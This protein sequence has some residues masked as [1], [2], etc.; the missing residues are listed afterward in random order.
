MNGRTP[1]RS[2][3]ASHSSV[4]ANA[5]ASRLGALVGLTIE[6]GAFSSGAD[7]PD[8][9]AHLREQFAAL[10]H[11]LEAAGIPPH[12]E[13]EAID[14]SDLLSLDMFGYSGLHYLRRVAVYLDAGRELPPPGDEQASKDALMEQF[15]Q[16]IEA[17]SGGI[18][19]R[20][21][22]R[23][24]RFRRHFDHLLLHSDAEGY[25]LP[26]DFPNVIFVPDDE[27]AGGMVGSSPRLEAE[28]RRLVA[29]LGIPDD[30]DPDAEQ[31]WNAADT[32]GQAA[33]GWQR[34]GIEAFTCVRLLRAAE[35]S[36]TLGAA[37]VF[38]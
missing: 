21:F 35:R 11:H 2:L 31:L 20:V 32:Q 19:R 37:I 24:P 5:E 36:Q 27:V 12:N 28:C 22:A 18:L 10:N 33:A 15:Y 23:T 29:A 34:Y 16:Q 13:P 25:Y 9:R 4:G 30:M 17:G 26:H 6:V 14:S 7:D 3:G 38:C 8:G 1:R